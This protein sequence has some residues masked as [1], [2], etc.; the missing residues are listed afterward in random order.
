MKNLVIRTGKD[1]WVIYI[2]ILCNDKNNECVYGLANQSS[3]TNVLANLD[4]NPDIFHNE[5]RST[6]FL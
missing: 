4:N 6:T 2:I 1:T 3:I 5:N